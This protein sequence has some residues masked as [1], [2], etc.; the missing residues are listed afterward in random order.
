MAC[1]VTDR[2]W[3]ISRK[4]EAEHASSGVNICQRAS[5]AYVL[6]PEK[7]QLGATRLHELLDPKVLDIS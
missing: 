4:K 5:V 2:A 3:N 6:A 1:F 7:L